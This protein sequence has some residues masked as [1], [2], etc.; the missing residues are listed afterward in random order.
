MLEASVTQIEAVQNSSP[1]GEFEVTGPMTSPLVEAGPASVSK[2]GD[3]I[4]VFWG[5][6]T[7]AEPAGFAEQ[8]MASVVESARKDAYRFP[9]S[10]RSRANLALALIKA[11]RINEAATELQLALEIDP[12]DYFAVFTLARLHFIAGNISEAESLL[13]RFLNTRPDDPNVLLGLAVLSIQRNDFSGAE[14]LLQ[15]ALTEDRTLSSGRFLLGL[16]RLQLG[17]ARG[18]IAELKLATRTDVRVPALHHTLGVA[19]ALIEDFDRAERA[20]RTALALSPGSH[21]TVR[22]LCKSLLDQRKAV[23]AAD[24]LKPYLEKH[25]EDMD[26]RELL[27]R[28]Y[29][30]LE[31]YALARG[32]LRLVLSRL[33]E[34]VPRKRRS[35]LVGD[36]AATLA[37]EHRI[38]EA[39][40]G[41][42]KAIE[43]DPSASSIPYENLARLYLADTQMESALEILL[44][45]KRV[46]P[47]SE[48]T[49]VLVSHAYIRLNKFGEAV[50]EL[51]QFLNSGNAAADTYALLGW[52][53]S[54]IG[55][56]D[57][58][59]DIAKRG[60]NRYPRIPGI[61]NNLAY[62]YLQLGRPEEARDVLRKFPKHTERHTEFIATQGLLKLHEG[63]IPA[64]KRLYT[65]AARKA[66]ESGKGDLAKK[67][68]Q[69]LHLEL[70]R[71][72]ARKGDVEDAKAEIRRGLAI[73]VNVLPYDDHLK[74]LARQLPAP[75]E[76]LPSTRDGQHE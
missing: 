13:N 28:A 6:E 65:E 2:N 48:A 47:D 71:F 44:R 11:G 61:I 50:T 41:L 51:G 10:A 23:E 60:Y 52:L 18:A 19:Y 31:K 4:E 21:A 58:A 45:S 8:I 9:K 36:I 43:I 76:P 17:N 68:R 15:K 38:K 42:W 37:L 5:I 46:F 20:F 69:K 67:V 57:N 62:V 54:W 32:Q 74:Q 34:D 75:P 73:H 39:E 55:D 59:V 25:P 40:A 35:L 66:S 12:A 63:D 22:A 53:Y 26:A 56:L 3:S 27:A 70:A 1:P 14:M 72:F 49:C 33:G 24:T 64:A 30:D 16:V 29:I 7:H